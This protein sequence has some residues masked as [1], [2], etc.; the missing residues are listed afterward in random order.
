MSRAGVLG[1]GLYPRT[2]G[3]QGWSNG[4]IEIGIS[5]SRTRKDNNK[6]VVSPEDSSF[7]EKALR[8]WSPAT[9]RMQ[10]QK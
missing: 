5:E 7:L 10:C 9:L 2:T 3:A 6:L 8:G 4:L 1:H